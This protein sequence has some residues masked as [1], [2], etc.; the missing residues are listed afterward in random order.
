MR[1]YL[2]F[3]CV[4][5]AW[6]GLVQVGTSFQGSPSGRSPAGTSVGSRQELRQRTLEMLDDLVQRERFY[7]RRTGTF[8][9]ILGRLEFEVPED[10]K[11]R[12]QVQVVEAARDRLLLRAFTDFEALPGEGEPRSDQLWMNHSYQVQ[13]NFS[14]PSRQLALIAVD[15]EE[16]LPELVIERLQESASLDP[17]K[18]DFK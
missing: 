3:L 10:L 15:S 7:R 1:A 8:T 2:A 4:F 9:P 16:P 6:I 18:P 12:V 14:V 5:G 17:A 11:S 13:A